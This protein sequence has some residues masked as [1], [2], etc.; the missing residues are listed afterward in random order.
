M[1]GRVRTC[2]WPE[3]PRG[4]GRD[5]RDP[6]PLYVARFGTPGG[7]GRPVKTVY[8]GPRGVSTPAALG[9][10]HPHVGSLIHGPRRLL[11]HHLGTCPA[12]RQ[13]GLAKGGSFACP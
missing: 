9:K 13:P 12:A 8:A 1:D 2:R 3:T 11:G 4:V 7:T 6:S 5:V 10:F